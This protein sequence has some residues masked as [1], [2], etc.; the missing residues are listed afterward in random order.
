MKILLFFVAAFVAA[1]LLG[2]TLKTDIQPPVTTSAEAISCSPGDVREIAKMEAATKEFAVLHPDPLYFKIKDPT[3]KPI[4]FTTPDGTNGSG[5]EIRSGKKT[6]N[7]V[8]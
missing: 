4:S 3:G 7:Y 2:Y 5:Y 6:R 8:L 1:A